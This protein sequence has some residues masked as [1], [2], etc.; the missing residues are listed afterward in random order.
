[1]AR[2]GGR[3][4]PVAAACATVEDGLALIDEARVT[5]AVERLIAEPRLLG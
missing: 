2:A 5:R 1:M 4:A 3:N